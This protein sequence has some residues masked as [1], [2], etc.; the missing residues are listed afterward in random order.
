MVPSATAPSYDI[1]AFWSRAGMRRVA[2]PPG[3]PDPAAAWRHGRPHDRHATPRARSPRR[4]S[5]ASARARA[6]AWRRR[7]C[8][9]HLHDGL[10]L[11]ARDAHRRPGRRHMIAS[12]RR[13]R[14][15]TAYLAQDGRWFWLLAAAGRPALAGPR[16]RASAARTCARRALAEHRDPPR[17]RRVAGRG[18]R[19]G[20]AQRTL[21]E[22]GGDLRPRERV[23]G[24][25]ATRSRRRCR[26][27]VAQASG[28]F[29]RSTGRDGASADGQHA[30][31]TSTARRWR[32]AASRRSWGSTPRRCCSRW[33]TTGTRSS[34]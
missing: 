16:A 12:T 22:W 2:D 32:R 3:W 14:S 4:C 29:A 19:R 11:H 1:G 6:S 24:A 7:C 8:A 31:L 13:T 5:R 10:G 18:T 26:I 20:F 25:G 9:R 21:D 34:R 33:A 30:G 27:P 15:S 17:E 28:A 23:V